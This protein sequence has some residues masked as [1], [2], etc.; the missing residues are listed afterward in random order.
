MYQQ[1][2]RHVSV[3]VL[4]PAVVLALV[5]SSVLVVLVVDGLVVD[6]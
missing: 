5:V 6:L 4:V 1:D 3:L 2:L